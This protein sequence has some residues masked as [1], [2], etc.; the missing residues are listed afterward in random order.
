MFCTARVICQVRVFRKL[1]TASIIEYYH[2]DKV[3]WWYQEHGFS[4]PDHRLVRDSRDNPWLEVEYID[5]RTSD[6]LVADQHSAIDDFLNSYGTILQSILE[7]PEEP[8]N[9]DQKLEEFMYGGD[10]YVFDVE[11]GFAYLEDDPVFLCFPK[12][13]FIHGVSEFFS[14]VTELCE[15]GVVSENIVEKARSVG[16]KTI[17]KPGCFDKYGPFRRLK[18]SYPG[19]VRLR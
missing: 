3:F 5:E 10:F 18:A 11:P 1:R 4:L 19:F 9:T 17:G 15:D 6:E 16:T 2:L 12:Q 8:F 13:R 14:G 7:N